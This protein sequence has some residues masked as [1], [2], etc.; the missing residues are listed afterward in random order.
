[1]IRTPSQTRTR[2]CWRLTNPPSW[3]DSQLKTFL[4]RN[5]IPNPQPS[6]RDSLLAKARENYQSIATKLGETTSYPGN[7]L[8][9]SWSESDL[10][11]WCDERGIPVPQHSSRDK[12]IARVRRNSRIASNQLKAYNSS[13]ASSAAAAT[14]SLSA[15]ILDAWSDS[16]IK[17]WCDKNGIKVPQ[18]SKRNELIALAR[19]HWA[20]VH[21]ADSAYGAA[22]SKARN[23]YAKATDDASLYGNWIYEEAMGYVDWVK[24]QLGLT[25][26]S[27][28]VEASRSATSA[29]GEASKSAKSVASSL[30]SVASRASV[31][32]SRAAEKEGK[33]DAKKIGD[34]A[35]KSVTK[36][37]NRVE[38]AWQKATDYVK[39][40]L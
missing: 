11:A 27:A 16:Q 36:G 33:K 14:E 4:D 10:K 6:T 7:W 39:E 37:K 23:Q 5:G 17:E 28:S 1:M 15:A 29:S 9:D 35:A 40:E 31:S 25:A 19:R 32:A 26:S 12:L 24:S 21:A 2:K 13:L 8:Y 30:S 34:A 18:G 38:E 22:T 3:S 20:R